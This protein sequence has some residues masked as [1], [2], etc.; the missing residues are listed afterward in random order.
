MFGGVPMNL[1][2]RLSVE[3]SPNSA[4]VAIDLI[5]CAKL[6][7]DRGLGG[8]V[9]PAGGLFLQAPAAAVHRRRGAR[10]AGGVHSRL[11]GSVMRRPAAAINHFNSATRSYTAAGAIF[12]C[13]GALPGNGNRRLETNEHEKI[14][15]GPGARRRAAVGGLAAGAIVWSTVA[16]AVEAIADL[17][18]RVSPSVVTV[19]TTQTRSPATSGRPELRL[20]R[21]LALRGVLQ[22]LRHARGRARHARPRRP[23]GPRDDPPGP[24]LG[25]RHRVGRLHHHQQPRRRGRRRG[26]GALRT[27]SATSRP[28][29]SAP[30]RSRTSRC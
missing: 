9:E 1:E 6:A 15:T 7:R 8:P 4:G 27:T 11:A 26:E 29:S 3:D 18:D 22:A 23:A 19:F 12:A 21:G 2:L 30:T 24:R 5:R 20:P 17:V 10:P 14:C 28:R 13:P 16:A 25:L